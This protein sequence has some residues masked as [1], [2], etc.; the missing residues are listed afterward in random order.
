MFYYAGK[1]GQC[2]GFLQEAGLS[3]LLKPLDFYPKYYII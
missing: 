3:L 2:Q 1:A